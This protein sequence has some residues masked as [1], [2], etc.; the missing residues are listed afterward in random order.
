MSKQLTPLRIKIS[1]WASKGFLT[2]FTLIELLVVIAIIALL[3]AILMPA[4]NRAK[5]QARR[6]SCQSNLRQIGMA[7]A[8]YA[9]DHDQYIPS[10][11]SWDN[12]VQTWFQYLMPYLGLQHLV[13]ATDIELP[14]TTA[15]AG[16][17]R[18]AEAAGSTVPDYRNVKI[19]RCPSYPDKE[20]TVCYVIN[21]FI[22]N[23]ANPLG[24][25]PGREDPYKITQ[26]RNLSKVI[27]LADNDDGLPYREIIKRVP[28]K[29][30]PYTDDWKAATRCDVW[31]QDHLGSS[32]NSNSNQWEYG[33]RVGQDRHKKGYNALF[34]DWHTRHIPTAGSDFLG[35]M[36]KA[37]ELNLWRLKN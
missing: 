12:D 35:G 9:D 20:Q 24:E 23:T 25:Y 18:N 28:S 11:T 33:R 17:L 14:P 27:Y 10:G 2:G 13:H 7:A 1:N 16:V 34:F 29:V 6:V 3:M 30:P 32:D 15:A 36:T 4:L 26:Y 5:E 8:M 37:E 31:H 22:F 19:F 21:T